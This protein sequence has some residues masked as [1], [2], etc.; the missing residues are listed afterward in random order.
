MTTGYV[1]RFK[2]KFVSAADSVMAFGKGG[3]TFKLGGNV[4]QQVSCAGINPGATAA[5]NVLAFFSI[6]PICF[7]AANRGVLI[8]AG[9]SFGSTANNKRLKIIFNPAT[10]VVG[11][12]VGASGVTICDT[13]T[14]ATNGGGWS[15]A[16]QVIKYG[17]L[18]SNTQIGIH[19][20][21]QIGNAVAALLAPSLIT[22]TES[23][24]ILVAVTGNASTATTDIVFNWLAVSA[25]NN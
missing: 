23:G 20:Q 9:G 12:T 16:A 1:Q 19:T 11:S 22:A 8:E 2:G 10:A 3:I 21:A 14:V 6:P 17:G 7:D 4:N 15:M 13:G 25:F 24:A 18:A 5:D